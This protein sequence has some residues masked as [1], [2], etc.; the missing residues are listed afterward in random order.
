MSLK[1]RKFTDLL[2]RYLETRQEW[3]R[4]GRQPR[5]AV[6]DDYVRARDV[7]NKAISELADKL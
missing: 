6:R 5:G 4:N 3:V 1:F 2:D 7:I